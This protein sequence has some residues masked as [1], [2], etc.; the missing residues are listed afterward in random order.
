MDGHTGCGSPGGDALTRF[1]VPLLLFTLVYVIAV[2]SYTVWDF[3]I[4]AG[5]SAGFLLLD[6]P[7]EDLTGAEAGPSLPHRLL[8]LVPFG[9]ALVVDITRGALD[10]MLLSMKLRPVGQAGIVGIPIGERTPL[11]MHVS[12]LALSLSPGSIV[13]RLDMARRVMWVHVVDA[14]DPEGV[15]RHYQ[16]F[17]DRYQ[18]HVFP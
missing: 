10:V 7:E 12:M 9:V 16:N 4:G 2:Q 17:Y 3:L 6:R 13:V 5:L 8:W 1:A 14:S 15:R 18:R 11:G